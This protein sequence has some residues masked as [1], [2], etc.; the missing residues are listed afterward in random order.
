M[1]DID[2]LRKNI[3]SEKWPVETGIG[4]PPQPY[5][6]GLG[7]IRL[8]M[9]DKS[10]IN[11]YS[12]DIE[13]ETKFLHT[14]RENFWSKSLHGSYKNILYDVVPTNY[15][16][17][18][19]QVNIVCQSGKNPTDVFSNVKVT[20]MDEF[21]LEEGKELFHNYSDF[22]DIELLTDHVITQVK[23]DFSPPYPVNYRFNILPKLVVPNEAQNINA[24]NNYGN[25][26]NNWEII[27]G[28]LNSINK[29]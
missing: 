15:D 23:F 18:W 11:F 3:I 4:S 7:C 19:K 20:K 9:K 29:T 2:Y 27:S 22:H 6:H 5:Y 10:F 12:K 13:A 21:V 26:E 1:F 25:E 14:H 16:T 24:L 8:A 28:I 17:G